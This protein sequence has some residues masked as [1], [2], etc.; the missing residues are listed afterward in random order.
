MFASKF[1]QSS[2]ELLVRMVDRDLRDKILDDFSEAWASK[3]EIS[4]TYFIYY[5]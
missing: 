3:A 4:T 5:S 1:N 2:R